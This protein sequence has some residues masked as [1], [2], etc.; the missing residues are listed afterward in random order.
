VPL[1][2]LIKGAGEQASG[3]AHRLFRCGFRVIMS[4][5]PAPTAVR[6]RVSFAS[7]LFEGSIQVEGVEGRAWSLSGLP[8]LSG[9]DWS[10]IPV[11]PDP[12][13]TLGGRWRPQVIIDARILKR[14]EG[15]RV[16]QAPLVIGYGPGLEAGRD[17][18]VV[19]ETDRGHD[20]G[21]IITRGQAAEDTGVPGTIAGHS[22]GRV[23]RAPC[24]GA[25][26]VLLDIGSSVSAGDELARVAGSSVHAAVD[27]V[28]RGMAHPGIAVRRGQKLGDVDPRGDLRA[29]RTISDKART[30]SGAALEAI[31]HHFGLQPPTP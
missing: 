30:I 16:E 24:D 15:N 28:V 6:R 26:E 9:F 29:C 23:L 5:L 17:V 22:L 11:L 31:L 1:R 7:A 3:T 19:V 12:D 13:D 2:V 4:D 8:T 10:H 25:L 14:N 18:H 27:G 20:L 21:R